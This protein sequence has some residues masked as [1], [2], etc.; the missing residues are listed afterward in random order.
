MFYVRVSETHAL[1]EGNLIDTTFE[2]NDWITWEEREDGIYATSVHPILSYKSSLSVNGIKPGDRL[3]MLDSLEVHK[4]E[5]ADK[6]FQA[7]SPGDY[8]V[9]SFE[10]PTITGYEKQ[11]PSFLLNGF[12][13]AFTFNE[14][15][16][17]W[18]ISVW[19]LGLG[20]FGANIISAI[21]IPLVRGNWKQHTALL[22]VVFFAILFFLLQFSHH[23]FFIVKEEFSSEMAQETSL[24]KIYIL[25]YIALS[26]LYSLSYFQFKSEGKH[27]LFAIPSVLVGAFLLYQAF[28]IIYISK[29][30][31]VLQDS[32]ERVSA[33][34]VLW[35]VLG[36]IYLHLSA[37]WNEKSIKQFWS[38]FLMVFAAVLGILYYTFTPELGFIGEE[39]VLLG[40]QVF[41]F[42]PLVNA[43]YF[44][45][46]FGKVR[47]VVTRT[48]QYAVFV[49]FT[50]ALYIL[51]NQLS[52]Y[53]LANNSF[54]KE[55]E[56]IA[57][58]LLV[59]LVRWIYLSNENKFRK[60]FTTAQQEK[61]QNIKSFVVQIPRFTSAKALR[62]AMVEQLKDYFAAEAVHLWWFGENNGNGSNNGSEDQEGGYNDSDYQRIF[63]EL[64]KSNT[65]WS[66]NKEIAPI[67]LDEN[68]E[69][70]I[71][72][73]A[74]TL[75]SPIT[76][77]DDNYALLMLGKKRRSVYNLSDL[78]IISQLVQQTQL[79]LNIIYLNTREKELIQ[80][81]YE[82]DLMALRSQINPHFLHNTLNTLTELV[83]ESPERAED[84]I[85]KLSYIFRYTTRESSKNLVP[86]ENEVKFVSTYLGLE[87]I[88][89]GER[90][91]VRINVNPAVKE[92]Q[93]PAFVLQT[94]IENSIK[95]GIAK[96][97]HPG[98]ITIDAF[99][100]G[101]YMVVEVYDNGPG[102]DTSK[103]FRSTG[104]SNTFK[105]FENIY[106]DKNLLYFKNTG[107][108]TLVRFKVPLE[109]MPATRQ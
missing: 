22:G 83:H 55:I 94:L 108:G 39:E 42:F 7:K 67:R 81:K 91:S 93:I 46:Q 53:V 10:R 84:A 13:L 71:L 34:Y 27:I 106:E 105:R 56:F 54:R 97:M 75:V 23:S 47:V 98:L 44:Q 48:L 107:D 74:Y 12:R 45:L 82:A 36:A 64:H 88:R 31:E 73:S 20:T 80:A 51:V 16:I 33:L 87:K 8:L 5:V 100:E 61:D 2:G 9:I 18:I 30:L 26:F 52:G 70:L 43:T 78:E 102:I 96:V 76:V 77:T 25:L 103:I 65:V 29:R 104:L 58:L 85:E 95:H 62:R 14:T 109:K 4:V 60:Y 90:L 40:Y 69:N 86:L 66:K 32:L 24:E 38:T 15:G 37:K 79:T 11:D 49:V 19:L 1:Q 63:Q 92:V 101:K 17:Y 89:F 50:S 41:L 68:L 99:A 28:D 35:H 6:I 72:K 57:V 3:R 59:L 21:L